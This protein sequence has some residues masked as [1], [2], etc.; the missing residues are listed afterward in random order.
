MH[1]TMCIPPTSGNH[2]PIASVFLRG[3]MRFCTGIAVKAVG[4]Y[5]PAEAAAEQYRPGGI[6]QDHHPAITVLHLQTVLSPDCERVP[7]TG[8]AYKPAVRWN[9]S[10]HVSNPSNPHIKPNR[11]ALLIAPTLRFIP[12]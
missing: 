11:L 1:P 3:W 6:V 10:N 9:A 12:V 8:V 4:C 7:A 5:A 2:R